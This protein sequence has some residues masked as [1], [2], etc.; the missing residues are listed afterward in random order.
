[1]PTNLTDVVAIYANYYNFAAVKRDRSIF[2]WGDN[3]RGQFNPPVA[4]SSNLTAIACGYHCY[5]ALQDDG[6]MIAWGEN[7]AHQTEVPKPADP[8]FA[9]SSGGG[10]CLALTRPA[11]PVIIQQPSDR[12]AYTGRSAN[13]SLR[14]K[15]S[16]PLI[17]QWQFNQNNIS[18]ATNATLVLDNVQ[19]TN[20]GLYRVR[21]TNALGN[22]VSDEA[23]LTAVDSPPVLIQPASNQV[24]CLTRSARFAVVA[25]GSGPLHFQWRFNGVDIPA[26]TNSTL[27][28]DKL[29]LGNAGNYSVRINNPFGTIDSPAANLAVVNVLAW[30]DNQLR[31]TEVASNA[32]DVVAI[33]CGQNHSLALRA[34]GSVVA[35]GDDSSGQ[36]DVP[37]AATNIV[38][39]S[40][41][42][43]HSLA[44]RS[45]G[46]VI[47][48][49]ADDYGQNAVPADATNVVKIADG[50]DF[51]LALRANGS[52]V[53]WGRNDLGQATVPAEATNVIA[54]AAGV[55]HSVAL[56]NDGLLLAWGNDDLSQTDIPPDLT[57]V[58]AIAAGAAHSLALQAD[59]TLSGW[60]YDVAG[61][62]DPPATATNISAFCGGLYGSLALKTNGTIIGWGSSI[63]GEASAPAPYTNV[64]AIAAGF[65]HSLALI[66]WPATPSLNPVGSGFDSTNGG[67]HMHAQGLSGYWP[68][69]IATSTNLIQWTPILT[70]PPTYDLMDILDLSATNTVLRFYRAIE[71]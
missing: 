36:I 45:N 14:V 4:L 34:D 3:S 54:I 65:Y 71:Q 56:R 52:I 23:T 30:G 1:V 25:D 49:G 27:Q 32:T 8:V 59:G 28:L 20:T 41:G 40:G 53:A 62:A 61:Q 22:V 2:L 57:N 39:V 29:N 42:Q 46:S 64:I 58:V 67:F 44:L 51:A 21:I 70:N 37:A 47:A 66:S 48:W 69:V 60:G 13:L 7:Y 68:V 10:H 38:A 12:S 35:W 19:L 26:A 15:G 31:Q 6:T 11:G 33:A 50:G 63:Y 9:I 18:G 16:S 55:L 5:L 24:G 17:Y 43:N